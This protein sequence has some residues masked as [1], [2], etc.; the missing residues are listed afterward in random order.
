[1]SD[2]ILLS[3]DHNG[4]ELKSMLASLLRSQ[5]YQCVDIGPFDTAKKVDYVD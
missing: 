4:I 3:S 5:G 1:M 2:P